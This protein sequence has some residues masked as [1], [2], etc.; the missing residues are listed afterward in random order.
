MSCYYQGCSRPGTNKEHIPP[1]S[2]FPKDQRNQLL[3]VRSCGLHNNEKSSDDIYV[4]AQILMN[5]SPSNRSREVWKQSVLPQLDYS[6]EAL[7]KTL[8][9]GAI[10]LPSGAVRYKV[11][12]ARVDGF[13]NALSCGI[14]FKACG[15]RL[16][17]QY[18][19]EHV[20]HNFCDPEETPE[21]KELKNHLLS[22]PA[23]CQPPRARG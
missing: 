5:A 1:K 2:F 8:A 10:P 7:R 4:L 13:F 22:W 19:I 20:Y 21:E 3:T 11:D 18:S 14:V 9:S 23:P 17:V 16:P 15:E 6:G 12:T